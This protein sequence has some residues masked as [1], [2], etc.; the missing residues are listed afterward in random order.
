[1]E[2]HKQKNVELE[3]K[4]QETAALKARDSGESDAG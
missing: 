1:M 2:Q 4:L 3:K